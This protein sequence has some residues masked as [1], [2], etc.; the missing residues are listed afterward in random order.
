MKL[1]WKFIKGDRISAHLSVYGHYVISHRP[2]EFIIC[3]RPPYEHHNLGTFKTFEEAQAVG[4]KHSAITK[5]KA[6]FT[7]IGSECNKQVLVIR[8]LGPWDQHP[9]VTNDAEGVVAKLIESG[10]LSPSQR[11]HYYDSAGQLD[12]LLVENGKFAGFNHLPKKD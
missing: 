9:T 5:G 3:Y 4:E 8:D 11:L 12:E 7:I 1:N 10:Y 6:N 2:A